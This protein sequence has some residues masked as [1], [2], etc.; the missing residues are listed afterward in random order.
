MG[1]PTDNL[2]ST[3]HEVPVERR[4]NRTLSDADID[5]IA[6]RLKEHFVKDFYTD[7]GRGVWGTVR[8]G[9]VWII[10]AGCVYFAAK[11]QSFSK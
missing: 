10:L 2:V 1:D 4:I 6:L 9:L 8:K 11:G 3:P 7:I 5:A